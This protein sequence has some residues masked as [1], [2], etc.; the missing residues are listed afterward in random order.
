MPVLEETANP[1]NFVR[2]PLVERFIERETIHIDDLA[3]SESEFPWGEDPRDRAGESNHAGQ[4]R[5]FARVLRL[6]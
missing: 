4:R 6:G 1:I 5:Y 2:L 3:A